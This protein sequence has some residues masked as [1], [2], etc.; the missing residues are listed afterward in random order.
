MKFSRPIKCPNL[1]CRVTLPRWSRFK[2]QGNHKIPRVHVIRIYLFRMLDL[3]PRVVALLSSSHSSLSSVDKNYSRLRHD[4]KYNNT[5]FSLNRAAS[6]FKK[7]FILPFRLSDR[8]F[9]SLRAPQSVSRL[10]EIRQSTDFEAP[11]LWKRSVGI[12]ESVLL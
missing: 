5:T 2:C 9:C 4:R 6:F 10:H 8:N 7:T 11:E 12:C 1:C 3:F